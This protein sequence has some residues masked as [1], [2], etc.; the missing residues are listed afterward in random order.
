MADSQDLETHAAELRSRIKD[1]RERRVTAQKAAAA[2]LTL[3]K[4]LE[5]AQRDRSSST[6]DHI[7][8]LRAEIESTR[9]ELIGRTH[10]VDWKRLQFQTLDQ[11]YPSNSQR[12]NLIKAFEVEARWRAEHNNSDQAKKYDLILA[13][14]M[15]VS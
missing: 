3:R 1:T 14:T 7:E 2:E 13:P 5:Q 10:T 4:A 11:T 15:G 8:K 6:T 9:R 12:E